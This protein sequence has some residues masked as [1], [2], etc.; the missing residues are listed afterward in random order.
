MSNQ[1]DIDK[2]FDDLN[3]D[4]N[5]QSVDESQQ[6][7]TDLTINN[8]NDGQIDIDPNVVYSK[9]NS[10][11][12]T[13]DKILKAAQYIVE[14]EPDADSIASTASVISSVKDV[15]KEFTVLHRDKMRFEQ[16][17]ELEMLKF[18]QR[19][20]LA[21]IRANDGKS[22]DIDQQ[23]SIDVIE[24]SQEQIIE[25]IMNIEESKE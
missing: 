18:E 8:T 25:Q 23:D 20:Q 7:P 10:L 24:F 15:I 14:A 5:I 12:N 13:G 2:L 17:K 9:L 22:I 21:Q 1:L 19:K 16:Q 6:P 3:V 11:I 4:E